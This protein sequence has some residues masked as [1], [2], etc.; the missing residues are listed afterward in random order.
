M[1]IKALAG[2][3]VIAALGWYSTPLAVRA[4]VVGDG[5]AGRAPQTVAE[6]EEIFEQVSNWG[7][8]GDDDE[9]GTMNLVTNE[10]QAGRGARADRHRRLARAYARDGA[11]RGHA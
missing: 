4:Q 7:R 1:K 8:W 9:I 2:A 10:T 11:S 6:F 5:N 3:A